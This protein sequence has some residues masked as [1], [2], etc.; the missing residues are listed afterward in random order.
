MDLHQIENILA[1]E[2]EQSISKAAEKLYLTQSALNQQLLRLE[3]E[4]GVRL[5]ERRKH[6]MI[7]TYAG[8]I[9][10][11]TAR[12]MVDMKQ[13][14]Y[15]IIH[16]I[17]E[18]TAGEISVAY[19]PERGSLMF[20]RVYPHFHERY[21]KITFRIR[22]ARVK[23]MEQLLL[24]KEV[25]M[26]FLTYA[27]DL[28]HPGLEY[29]DIEKERIILGL[30][31]NHPLAYLA[32]ERSWETL[33]EF[34]LRRLKEENF[35]L[36]SRETRIR[37]MTDRAFALA[38][39]QPNILFESTSTST[40]INM[41]RNQVCPAFFPQSYIEPESPIVYFTVPPRDSWMRCMAY[42]KGTYLTKAE[43]YFIKLATL[44]TRGEL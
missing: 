34:D 22:E 2:Q 32:G 44:A 1:I 26:A 33:P 7:P 29:V 30:P 31:Q 28:K 16:D 25:T 10:L 19:T 37:E 36:S 39:F 13:E 27:Q 42:V 24:Q 35:I 9:Y 14:T 21:P 38:G 23:T 17:A 15:K 40:L 3:K 5:F 41:V 4:L 8:R 6:S 20:S 11:S 12:L 43:N 18:E